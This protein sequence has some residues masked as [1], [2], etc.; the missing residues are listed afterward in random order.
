[1]TVEWMGSKLNIFKIEVTAK[2][3]SSA[4]TIRQTGIVAAG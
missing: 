2:T 1:M 4:N 3:N